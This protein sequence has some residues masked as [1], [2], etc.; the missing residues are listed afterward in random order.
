MATDEG[1]G[2]SNLDRSVWH[3][4]KYGR[5]F[6]LQAKQ[7]ILRS[8]AYEV[9]EEMMTMTT[10]LRPKLKPE[11][12]K[13]EK[14][15]AAEEKP[16][17]SLGEVA[18][19]S[20]VAGEGIGSASNPTDAKAEESPAV[21][22]PQKPTPTEGSS[23]GGAYENL[24]GDS[25]DIMKLKKKLREIQKIKDSLAAGEVL[26]ANQKEKLS[27]KEGYLEELRLLESIVRSP[28]AAGAPDA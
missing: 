26:E 3:E 11:G 22:K 2:G 28:V 13:A 14:A 1:A 5:S 21:K 12:G 23:S 25:K 19:P 15:G 16:R 20:S 24:P 27:K 4:Q 18:S 17:P 10:G 9:P 7:K 8:K 6:L